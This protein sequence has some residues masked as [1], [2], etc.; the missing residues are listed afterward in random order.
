LDEAMKA[1]KLTYISYSK[2]QAF[3]DQ[4]ALAPLGASPVFMLQNTKKGE[5]AILMGMDTSSAKVFTNAN[6]GLV[7]KVLEEMISAGGLEEFNSVS[8]EKGSA[9]YLF[10]LIVS[11]LYGDT[12]DFEDSHHKKITFLEGDDEV[13]DNNSISKYEGCDGVLV[14]A[15]EDL[16][17]EF[18]LSKKTLVIAGKKY[19]NLLEALELLDGGWPT[20]AILTKNMKKT[21]VKKTAIKKT[22]GSVLS[23]DKVTYLNICKVAYE[24]GWGASIDGVGRPVF[25]FENTSTGAQTGFYRSSK[26]DVVSFHC[27]DA[28]ALDRYIQ[29]SALEEFNSLTDQEVESTYLNELF[30]A[31]IN[32]DTGDFEYENG[33]ETLLLDG[34]ESINAESLEDVKDCFGVWTLSSDSMEIK[35]NEN[36]KSLLINDR[37]MYETF[38]EL[39]EALFGNSEQVALLIKN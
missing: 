33:I 4:Y 18:D 5:I 14:I 10:D 39:F 16:K 1:D 37:E 9:Q 36:D 23:S 35:F 27:P 28:D 20:A 21:L 6:G 26:G 13:L 34:E 31:V 29:D 2:T 8:S 11:A 15:K 19:A 30:M 3:G 24:D 38:D 32:K 12:S 25:I 7:G 17:I 22:S